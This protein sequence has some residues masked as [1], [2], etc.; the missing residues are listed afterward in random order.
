[1]CDGMAHQSGRP[2]AES[3]QHHAPA[4][5]PTHHPSDHFDHCA[6]TPSCAGIVLAADALVKSTYGADSERVV[7]TA[8]LV[9]PTRSP[10]L[11]PPPPKA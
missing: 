4:R 8:A 6:N 7:Q 3:H 10:D 11:E 2:T 9:P 1:V 5:S